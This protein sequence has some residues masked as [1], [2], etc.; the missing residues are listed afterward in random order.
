MMPLMAS[1]ASR[2]RSV[3][4]DRRNRRDVAPSAQRYSKS[5]TATI[6]FQ[7]GDDQVSTAGG[8][9]ILSAHRQSRRHAVGF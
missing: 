7:R 4:A 2:G 6:V 5:A 3:A 8:W 9:A 1:C